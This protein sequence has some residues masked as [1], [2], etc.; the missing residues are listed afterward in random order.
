MKLTRIV[1]LTLTSAMTAMAGSPS[2]SYMLGMSRPSTHLLEVEVTF[3]GLPSG[4]SMLTLALPVW[5]TGRYVVLDP[6]GGV[7]S[8]DAF[9]GSNKPLRWKKTDKRTWMVETSGAPKVVARYEVFAD[10]FAQRTRGLNDERAFVDGTT[11]FM[12][13]ENYRWHPLTLTVRPYGSWH[14]TTGLDAVPGKPNTFTAPN[15]DHLADCPLEI[16]TQKDFVFTIDGKEHV[17]SITGEG[18]YDSTKLIADISTIV[19]KQA[20]FWGGLPYERYVFFLALSPRGS[21]GTEHINSCVM[22]ARPFIFKD[23]AA[24]GKFLGL[25]SHEFFH[26]WNVK[27]LRPAGLQTYD[28]SKENYVEELWVAEGTTSYYDDLLLVRAGMMT[29]EEYLSKLAEAINTDRERPGNLRK[30]LA[31]SSFDAWIGYWKS[32]RHAV[33]FDTDYYAR[34]AAVSFILDMAI[35][36]ATRNQRSL[37]DVLRTM[38]ARFPLG[39]GGYTNADLEAVCAEVGGKSFQEFFASYVYGAKQLPWAQALATV[40]LQLESASP[41][42]KPWLGLTAVDEGGRTRITRVVAGSPAYEAG[43]DVDDEILALN[44]YKVRSTDLA[45]RIS[46]MQEGEKAKLTVFRD[47]KL[48]EF[49]VIVRLPATPSVRVVKMEKPTALQKATYESWLSS[50][51]KSLR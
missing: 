29:K 12:Y 50:S 9:D 46:E 5:R 49:E 21:G 17:L 47:D 38:Y 23:P 2:V 26:T 45:A 37:D 15:Y 25:V 14:V 31:E 19:K 39:K 10:E 42:K 36:E 48:R 28:W 3:D 44:G 4:D 24:Y 51:P 32:T 1:L 43:L 40:G 7:V 41:E 35:R 20:E 6:A 34:G 8:F 33:N 27:R 16:G 13:S 18:N 11:V 22:G 30:S